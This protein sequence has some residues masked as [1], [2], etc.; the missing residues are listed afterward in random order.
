MLCYLVFSELYTT[1]NEPIC[2]RTMNWYP[3]TNLWFSTK[4]NE[5]CDYDM[6]TNNLFAFVC[7][8][9]SWN[10]VYIT[11]IIVCSRIK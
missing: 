4:C 8:A 3:R 11:K 1:Y 2:K 5:L 9:D 6:S 10:W 7:E